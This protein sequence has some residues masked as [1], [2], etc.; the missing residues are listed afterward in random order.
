L[1]HFYKR[2]IHITCELMAMAAP[3]RSNKPTTSDAVTNYDADMSRALWESLQDNYMRDN[4]AAVQLL[5]EDSILHPVGGLTEEDIIKQV[6]YMSLHEAKSSFSPEEDELLFEQWKSKPIEERSTELFSETTA[7]PVSL[8][9]AV[10]VTGQP[11]NRRHNSPPGGVGEENA[12][13]LANPAPARSHRRRSPV[14]MKKKGA[15]L[16]TNKLPVGMQP[17]QPPSL[18]APAIITISKNE[19]DE[20]NEDKQ[21][22]QALEASLAQ[23]KM[24]FE[25]KTQ[26]VL[27][28]SKEHYAVNNRWRNS[29]DVTD[30]NLTEEQQIELAIKISQQ[31]KLSNGCATPLFNT[32]SRST[33]SGSSRSSRSSDNSSPSTA[34]HAATGSSSLDWLPRQYHPPDRHVVGLPSGSRAGS[35]VSVGSLPSSMYN[36]NDSLIVRG[37]LRCIV[38][39]ASNV[40]HAHSNH[41]HFSLR[42][43]NIC[44]EFFQKRGHQVVAFLPKSRYNHASEEDK[45]TMNIMEESKLLVFAPPKSYDDLFAIKFAASRRGIIV[46]NDRFLDVKDR[47]DPNY[48][49]QV[50]KRR[51]QFSWF[52]DT[53]MVPDDPLGRNGPP[54]DEFLRHP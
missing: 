23:T 43:V 20:S 32:R 8:D 29:E 1:I 34:S 53:F 44:I 37:A 52:N 7:R 28:K 2:S 15:L 40:G 6:E 35:V 54:L 5:P 12:A 3:Q 39:D 19:E 21:L 18:S 13:I 16:A 9:L 49:E 31:E 51:L 25:E 50:E 36:P 41:K 26:L 33:S 11:I 17:E 14:A 30:I 42:G 45:Q 27:E 24:G 38:I 10:A 48:T 4:T 22:R 47:N 46:S